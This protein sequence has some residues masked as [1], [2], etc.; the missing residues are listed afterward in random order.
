[1]HKMIDREGRYWLLFFGF[2]EAGEGLRI[3]VI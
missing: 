2:Y 1:M 3:E